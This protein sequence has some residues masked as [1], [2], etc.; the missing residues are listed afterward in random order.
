M[1]QN[2]R[3]KTATPTSAAPAIALLITGALVALA[4]SWAVA[5]WAIDS[6]TKR[7]T[8]AGDLSPHDYA[9]WIEARSK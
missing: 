2:R 6:A 1:Q 4:L 7:S 8:A 3:A 5:S 9:A